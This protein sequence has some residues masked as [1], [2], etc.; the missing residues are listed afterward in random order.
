VKAFLLA[1]G[2]GT[3]LRPFTDNIPKCL[4]PVHDRPLLDIWFGLLQDHGIDEVLVNTHHHAGQVARAVADLQPRYRLKIHTC[5]EPKLLGSGGTVV[6]HAAFV[7]GN[8]HF[9]VVYADN[10]SRLDL[11][12]MIDAHRGFAA[13]GGVLTMGLF[14]AKTPAQCGIATLDDHQRIVDFVEKPDFPESDLANA[15]VYVATAD[16]IRAGRQAAAKVSGQP[17][18]FGHHILPLLKGRMYGYPIDVFHQDIGT[19]D[20]YR[21]AIAA[22]EHI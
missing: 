9:L 12:A 16:V 10:L 3:R 19:V 21:Q 14:H 1:A 15:G 22:W 7:D 6:E 18:D 4:I 13:R 2:L 8:P 17:L 20:A 11:T 5:F